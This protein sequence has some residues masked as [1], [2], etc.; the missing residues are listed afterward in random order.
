MKPVKQYKSLH[1][2]DITSV[3]FCLD[4]QL[5]HTC[6]MDGIINIVDT[7]AIKQ[8]DSAPQCKHLI[9]D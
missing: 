3:G 2:E 6:S 9:S 4:P 8:S 5:F 7:N 1:S